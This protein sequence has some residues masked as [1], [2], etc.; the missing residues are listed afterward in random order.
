MWTTFKRFSTIFDIFVP[1]FY[2]HYTHYVIPK[3][4]LNHLNSFHGG[5]FKLSTKFNADSLL[6]SHSHFEY[7]SH[8]V[9]M[10]SQWC[11]LSPLSS[12]VKLSL[13]THAHSLA[14]LSLV[15][16]L[17]QCHINSSRYVNN[18]WTFSRQTLYTN[19][20]FDVIDYKLKIEPI[21]VYVCFFF[22]QNQLCR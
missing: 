15:T 6:Y 17:H 12:T 4:F 16:R 14:P 5:M 20:S 19:G 7:H 9:H 22:S 11:R 1:Q 13:F 3:S 18:G 10:L 8:T 2:L 21:H